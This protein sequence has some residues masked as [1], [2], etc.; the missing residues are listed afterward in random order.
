MVESGVHLYGCHTNTAVEIERKRMLS[1]DRE[2]SV[3]AFGYNGKK[4]VSIILKK[5]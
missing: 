3:M 2:V 5:V 4:K 1:F